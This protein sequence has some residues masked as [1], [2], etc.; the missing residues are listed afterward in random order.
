[1]N[2]LNSAM[3]CEQ[4]GGYIRDGECLL[5]DEILT[6]TEVSCEKTLK[7]NW[8]TKS[9]YPVE[10]M[11]Y[12]GI[13]K[14]PFTK[15]LVDIRLCRFPLENI[16]Y[17]QKEHFDKLQRSV[18]Y[19]VINRDR[20]KSATIDEKKEMVSD[21][22]LLDMLKKRSVD[23]VNMGQQHAP[24]M[25][26]KGANKQITI[27]LLHFE[28]DKEKETM[29]KNI[30]DLISK[31]EVKKYWIVMESWVSDNPFI[32]PRN[33]PNRKEAIMISEYEKD[34]IKTKKII[35][36]FK[37]DL[38]GKPVWLK[39]REDISEPS[40][41]GDRWNF[42]MEDIMDEKMAQIRE[43]ILRKQIAKAKKEMMEEF[44]SKGMSEE[45]LKKASKTFDEVGEKIVKKMKRSYGDENG[46]R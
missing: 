21:S 20:F 5:E 33:D 23:I 9:M 12:L 6:D 22:Q 41:T 8:I 11:S 3:K 26:V 43:E 17:I 25:F 38:E 18:L 40:E 42:F 29:L 10:S 24:M 30:R 36:P 13:T 45:E 4:L 1:M 44:R 46:E 32:L 37:R 35:M 15:Q 7:G 34:V 28:N 27:I 2:K 39:K 16:E 14:T 19:R 31:G